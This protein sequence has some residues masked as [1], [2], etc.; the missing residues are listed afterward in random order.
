MFRAGERLEVL[1]IADGLGLARATI[2]RWFGTREQLVGKIVMAATEPILA[3]SRADVGGSGGDALLRTLDEF[4]RRLVGS[5]ALRRFLENESEQALGILCSDVGV[6]T[7]ALTRMFTGLIEAE[8]QNE[9]YE[10]PLEPEV[11]AN[12]LVKLGQAFLFNHGGAAI[13][14]DVHGLHEVQAALLR[15]TPPPRRS[16][17]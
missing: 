15:V 13:R 11:L 5:N 8:I 3:S 4:N 12:A 1:A 2:Y 9:S 6:V 10:P 14:G 16:A 17:P 7:P